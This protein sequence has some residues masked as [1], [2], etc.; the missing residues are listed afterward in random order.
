MGKVYLTFNT[1]KLYK[2][3]RDVKVKLRIKRAL[4][5]LSQNPYAGKKLKGDLAGQYSLRI[6][7]FRIIYYL[8]SN[9]NIIVTDIGHRQEINK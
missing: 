6:W 9:K 2:N 7:P 8:K 4:F 1:Q 5:K 3:I